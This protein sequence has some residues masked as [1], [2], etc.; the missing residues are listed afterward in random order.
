MRRFT[1]VV[2]IMIIIS[3]CTKPKDLEFVDV[4]NIRMIK[5]GLSESLVGVDVRFYNPN[6]QQVRL[7]DAD[8]KVYAN[9]A[10]LGNAFT[11][12]V[13]VIPKNDTFAVPLIL[14][15]NTATALAGAMQ[16]LADTTVAIKVEGN[17]K[18]GKAGVFVNYPI[19]YE[20]VQ[21]VA[22]LNLNF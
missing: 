13:I 22:D 7:K 17:V 5:W 16:T 3:S 6:N 20:K 1:A 19:S 8:A 9:S 21:R 12:T 2:L 4:Q 18:M 10:Y 11:D 14:K 15:L